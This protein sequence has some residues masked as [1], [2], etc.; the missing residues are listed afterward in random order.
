MTCLRNYKHLVYIVSAFVV[1][2]HAMASGPKEEFNEE[3]TIRNVQGLLGPDFVVFAAPMDEVSSGTYTRERYKFL[4]TQARAQ[5]GDF[6]SMVNMAGLL[7]KEKGC[8]KDHQQAFSWLEKALVVLKGQ[9][10][11]TLEIMG[12]HYRALEL[13]PE[14]RIRALHSAVQCYRRAVDVGQ[15][16]SRKYLASA[17][18]EI[19]TPASF[20]EAFKEYEIVSRQGDSYGVYMLAFLAANKLVPLENFSN[21]QEQIFKWIQIAA[22]DGF[23]KA[24]TQYIKMILDQEG[25]KRTEELGQKAYKLSLE[26]VGDN[27]EEGY[28]LLADCYIKGLGTPADPTKA[29]KT[30]MMGADQGNIQSLEKLAHIFEEGGFNQPVNLE[31]AFRLYSKAA[32]LG[33]VFSVNAVAHY[34]HHGLGGQKVDLPRAIECYRA[35][36]AGGILR[37]KMNLATALYDL[38]DERSVL[39]AIQIWEKTRI[40]EPYLSDVGLALAFSEGKGIKTDLDRALGYMMPY[41]DK[42]NGA[43]I[44]GMIYEKKG[45]LPSALRCYEACSKMYDK[46]VKKV[47]DAIASLKDK[48][49]RTL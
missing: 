45:D 16:E 43:Y 46:P 4:K 23:K 42:P 44:C 5:A 15:E 38:G 12:D 29:L 25:C 28:L 17:L 13:N 49:G 36:S 10:A 48:I 1:S 34:F 24:R 31:I 2:S 8:K 35:A 7:I 47:V 32:Q 14:T 6:N 22:E 26:E 39:E 20:L 3:E 9:P 18:M 30:L 40:A 37:F 33:S 21:P 41:Q 27:T 19:G 11:S